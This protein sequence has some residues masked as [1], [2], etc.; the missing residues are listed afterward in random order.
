[1]LAGSPDDRVEGMV[2]ATIVRWRAPLIDLGCAVV[3][4]ALAHRAGWTA[5]LPAFLVLGASLVAVTVI[6]ID[7]FRI[8]DRIVFPTLAVCTV[9]LALAAVVGGVGRG[10][11]AASI[12]ALA[13]FAFLFVFFF[14]FPRGMGFG[15]VKLAL[16]L[17][18]HLGW[19]GSVA[20]V[21][22]ALVERGLTAG[23]QLV[24]MGALVGSLLGTVIGVGVLVASKR[25]AAFPFGPALCLG[26]VVVITFSESFLR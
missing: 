6:D 26:T 23:I 19:A 10:L 20:T 24:L 18:L 8:P 3:M 13:Y 2:D 5:T 11:V 15:D 22:G 1:M 17:G 12:G 9:L 14:V 16:V 4:A 21:D 25:N 7:H